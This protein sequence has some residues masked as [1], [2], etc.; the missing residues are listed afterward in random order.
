[1][2]LEALARGEVRGTRFLAAAATPARKAW[3]LQQP[4]RG[5]LRI[6]AGALAALRAGRSLL[7]RGV[8]GVEGDF[9]FGDAVAV[10]HEGVVVAQGLANYG[11]EAAGRIRGLHSRD[12]AAALGAKDYDELI[13]RDNLVLV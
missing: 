11:A 6:D 12:I 9:A 8:I 1:E 5:E 10:I 4:S 3:I 13:H 2:G 7:P